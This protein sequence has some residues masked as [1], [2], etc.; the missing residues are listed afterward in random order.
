MG[1]YA[2]VDND[3]IVNTVIGDSYELIQ[4]I[5]KQTH[6]TFIVVEIKEGTN[7][8]IGYTYKN[9]KFTAPVEPIPDLPLPKNIV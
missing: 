1:V 2:I 5:T 4:Q 3:V 8:G 7:A 6:P 9:G